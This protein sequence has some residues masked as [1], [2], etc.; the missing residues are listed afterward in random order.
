MFSLQEA[1]SEKSYACL[2]AWEE[3]DRQMIRKIKDGMISDKVSF[4]FLEEYYE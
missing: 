2:Y 3:K 4:V 1:N